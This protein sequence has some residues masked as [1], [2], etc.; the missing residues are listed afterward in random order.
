MMKNH[1]HIVSARLPFELC[2]K[3]QNKIA[4]T[5]IFIYWDSIPLRR[6]SL[7]I[8]NE[9]TASQICSIWHLQNFK[10]PNN[11][12]MWYLNIF[13]E[14]SFYQRMWTDAHVMSMAD[15]SQTSHPPFSI[16][17]MCCLGLWLV[18]ILFRTNKGVRIKNFSNRD[19]S[20][21]AKV[22]LAALQMNL[23]AI[24]RGPSLDRFGIL[25]PFC[26]PPNRT[27]GKIWICKLKGGGQY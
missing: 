20:H 11:S 26:L 14:K 18:H 24:V 19:Y 1:V 21:M 6:M 5:N 13:W 7:H 12:E 15:D 3:L 23:I 4:V 17:G 16:V 2:L 27:P 25:L 10:L 8:S 9:K 22:T